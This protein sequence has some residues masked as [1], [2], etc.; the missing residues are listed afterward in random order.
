[1]LQKKGQ[2]AAT[3]LTLKMEGGGHVPGNAGGL[4]KLGNARKWIIPSSPQK[5]PAGALIL[6][7]EV[8]VRL[9]I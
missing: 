1:M 2:R 5:G 9:L 8:Q 4:W 6:G 7:S 3:L